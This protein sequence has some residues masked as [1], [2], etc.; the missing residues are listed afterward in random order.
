MSD[1]T[2]AHTHATPDPEMIQ[3]VGA[4]HPAAEGRRALLAGLG[5]LTAGALL[6]RKAE[7]GP[8]DPPP[9]PVNG[10]G[11]TLEQ[12]IQ[13]TA[14]PS[15]IAEPR[16]PFPDPS[17]GTFDITQPGSYYLTQNLTSGIT[18]RAS[19]VVLD[20]C[21]FVVTTQF[22]SEI[23]SLQTGCERICIRNGQ[24]DGRGIA[25]G[26]RSNLSD[27]RL[28]L[29]DLAIVGTNLGTISAGIDIFSG[30]VICR[31]VIVSGYRAGISI[32]AGLIDNCHTINCAGGV[33]I[34]S[35]PG[36]IQACTVRNSTEFAGI[37]TFAA[38][39]SILNCQVVANGSSRAILASVATLIDGC[40]TLGGSGISAGNHS[41]ILRSSVRSA[42]GVGIDVQGFCR[43][44]DCNVS[45]TT[46]ISG[47]DP[48]IGIRANQRLRLERSIIATSAGV[49]IRTTSFDSTISDCTIT[50]SGST[51]IEIVGPATVE[52]CHLANNQGGILFDALTRVASCHLDF[53]GNFG[54]WATSTSVGGTFITD[55]DITRHGNGVDLRSNS[56]SGVMRCRFAGNTNNIISP[57]GNFQLTAV[58]AAAANSATNPNV[59]IAL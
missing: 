31:R 13:R 12:I 51:G 6:S 21:G 42:R 55:C 30:S 25:Y 56:G 39:C 4:D 19:D 34:T 40:N 28:V 26:I 15:G 44:A 23:I 58:G 18:I 50:S 41:S 37:A 36:I 17:T 7:A 57:A 5:L 9:G 38:G 33:Q 29:E 24:L 35:S 54:I 46:A 10:T 43:V 59:N 20:L 11:V 27:L 47:G 1:S 53:N 14:L 45:G 49:G 2:P 32:P 16:R 22:N 48:G 3:P 52:R 8:L